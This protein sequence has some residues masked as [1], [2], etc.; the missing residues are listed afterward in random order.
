MEIL[1]INKYLLE[2]RMRR[3]KKT[4]QEE[5]DFMFLLSFFFKINVIWGLITLITFL[6]NF[7]FLIYINFFY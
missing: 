5:Q 1:K 2:N 6:F 3:L 4:K 7:F